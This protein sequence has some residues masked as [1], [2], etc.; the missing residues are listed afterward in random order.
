M[1]QLTLSLNAR[2]LIMTES[3]IFTATSVM[4]QLWLADAA[5]CCPQ[6]NSP[7]PTASLPSVAFNLS[8][9]HQLEPKWRST[10]LLLHGS[11]LQKVARFMKGERDHPQV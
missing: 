10:T 11:T 3:I 5:G 6:K 9:S 1:V 2:K 4:Q 8:F 7:N